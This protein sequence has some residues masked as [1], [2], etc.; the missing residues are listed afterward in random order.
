[1]VGEVIDKVGGIGKTSNVVDMIGE[2]GKSVG[3]RKSLVEI[4]VE[5]AVV[6]AIETGLDVVG[7]GGEIE[8]RLGVD[9]GVERELRVGVFEVANS[10]MPKIERY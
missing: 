4:V 3:V 9:F 7:I 5:Q 6:H 8:R 1:M 10:L 2:V